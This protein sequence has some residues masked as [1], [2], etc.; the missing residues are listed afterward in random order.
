LGGRGTKFSDKKSEKEIDFLMEGQVIEY[1]VISE[2]IVIVRTATVIKTEL[3]HSLGTIFTAI[4]PYR[5][6]VRLTRREIKR[7][8]Y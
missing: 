6:Q 4:T 7:F 5:N 2:G 8:I 3:H 1:E